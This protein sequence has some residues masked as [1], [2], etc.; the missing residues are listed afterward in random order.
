MPDKVERKLTVKQQRFA[1]LYDGN[2]V[3]AAREAGYKGNNITLAAVA[4]EN[5]AKPHI[6]NIIKKRE[7]KRNE[8]G[9]ADREGRQKFWTEVM[10]DKAELTKD[11]LRSSELLGR[12]EADFTDNIKQ[13][14]EIKVTVVDSFG[15]EEND[16]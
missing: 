11:R 4:R 8:K 3:K 9:I 6:L 12:S 7:N 14:G 1:D 15:T 2:G 16:K 13:A 5:L 10:D